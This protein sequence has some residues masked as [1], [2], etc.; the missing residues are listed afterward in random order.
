MKIILSFFFNNFD[1]MT[2]L[3]RNEDSHKNNSRNVADIIIIIIK[4]KFKKNTQTK[5]QMCACYYKP[6]LTWNLRGYV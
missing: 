3:I 4:M 1:H 2:S 5:T 6:I